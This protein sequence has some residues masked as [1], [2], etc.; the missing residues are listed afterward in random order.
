M[1]TKEKRTGAATFMMLAMPAIAM[2]LINP[3][4]IK[5]ANPT[6]PDTSKKVYNITTYGNL[7]TADSS[8]Y[9]LNGKKVSKAEFDKL[10]TRDVMNISWVSAENAA[11]VLDN[12]TGANSVLF[13]TT[14]DSEEGKK[15]LDRINKLPH[16]HG[17]IAGEGKHGVYIGSSNTPAEVADLNS[18]GNYAV[19]NAGGGTSI[20]SG[21]SGVITVSGKKS[22]SHSTNI[23]GSGLSY[24]LAEGNGGNEVVALSN[25][26]PVTAH[27]TIDRL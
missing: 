25:G 11:K 12:F 9:V 18:A 23:T 26:K 4:C 14:D 3:V 16:N 19:T 24:V 22:S 1:E 17:F 2:L 7:S 15:I 6:G 5:A 13:V 8:I 21:N 27:R 10:D 20:A